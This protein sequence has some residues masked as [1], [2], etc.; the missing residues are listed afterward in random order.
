MGRRVMN[1]LLKFILFNIILVA[2]IPIN[3]VYASYVELRF[4]GIEKQKYESTCGVA[5]LSSIL[6]K[7]FS[8][9]KNEL[10]LLNYFPLKPE[11]SFVDLAQVAE[12]FG[13]KTIGV[14][15]TLSQLNQIH[16]PT[17]LYLNRFGKGHFVILKGIDD[18]WVQI[19]DPA[20]GNLN[21]T[22]ERFNRYWLQPEGM[23]RALIFNKSSDLKVIKDRIYK[24]IVLTN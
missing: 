7:Y 22:R 3:H 1:L 24:K 23:G 4:A 17:I 18:A 15:I 13:I 10:E 19:E 9:D 16:S 6:R 14:K 8:I 21:Y 12:K 20:W 5:S 2:I 11:Y